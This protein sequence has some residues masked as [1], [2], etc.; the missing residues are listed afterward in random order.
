MERHADYIYG[1]VTVI[2]S[3]PAFNTTLKDTLRHIK[4]KLELLYTIP[5]IL[6]NRHI[7][8]FNL[9]STVEHGLGGIQQDTLDVHLLRNTLTAEQLNQKI[10]IALHVGLPNGETIEYIHVG[11]YKAS[12]WL[13]AKDN[14]IKLECTTRLN[15][16][17][18]IKENVIRSNCK[19][20]T[21]MQDVIKALYNNDLT[22]KVGCIN[23]TLI[24]AYLIK[25]NIL[26]QLG[27][28]CEASQG[29]LR[30]TH[31]AFELVPFAL[32]TPCCTLLEGKKELI[33]STAQDTDFLMDIKKVEIL[34]SR[35]VKSATECLYSARDLELKG[36]AHINIEAGVNGA[37]FLHYFNFDKYAY[38]ADY[39]VGIDKVY[40][41]IY[42]AYPSDKTIG[43]EIWGQSVTSHVAESKNITDGSITYI[44]N[45]YIQTDEHIRM[46]ESSI[47]NAETKTLQYRG[48]P[49]L[50]IGDTVTVDGKNILI[51]SHTLNFN[52]GLTGE[53]KGVVL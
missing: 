32:S 39:A 1:G 20:N 5:V 36:H 18:L 35:F 3:T 46:F 11:T 9:N 8:T 26:E 27:L 19:L 25:P 50:Q 12:R 24:D 45:P 43:V 44:E 42:N 2:T 14:T 15:T 40:L 33:L 7:I 30:Y 17:I 31:N 16:D 48:D 53:I 13:I 37:I 21:Y 51:T 10:D 41:N 22:V 49:R 6:T 23:P 38:I 28:L 4:V 29:I 52:G 34:T 47:F